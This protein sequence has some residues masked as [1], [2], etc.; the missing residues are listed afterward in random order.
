MLDTP[1]HVIE[2][3]VGEACDVTHCHHRHIGP[4]D[5]HEVVGEHTVGEVEVIAVEPLNIGHAADRLDNDVSG[6]PGA[7]GKRHAIVVELSHSLTK[8]EGHAVRFMMGLHCR[9]ELCTER[10]HH[11]LRVVRRDRDLA[12]ELSRGGGDLA[13]DES[14][15]HD[16]Q[17]RPGG[18]S[19]AQGECILGRAQHRGLRPGHGEV[20]RA[21]AAGDDQPVEGIR[22]IVDHHHA[23]S[24]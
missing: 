15:T 10:A 3:R 1:R 11:R 18:E 2:A 9:T 14:G 6:E 24:E 7:I 5:P 23:R 20:A 22:R 8:V 16:Q 17:R 4:Q 21:D 19:I 13:A 12:A